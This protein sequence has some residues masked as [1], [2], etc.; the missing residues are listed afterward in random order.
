MTQPLAQ[1]KPEKHI[2]FHHADGVNAV[3]ALNFHWP[4][5]CTL[6]LLM[7]I[8]GIPAILIVSLLL[9]SLLFGPVESTLLLSLINPLYY[10]SPWA[11]IV[12][13]GSGAIFF[14][15]MPWQFSPALRGKYP[16]WHRASGRLVLLSGY[17]MAVSGIWMHLF[18]TPDE[19]GMRFIGLLALSCGMVLGFSMAFYAVLQR[20]F[21]RHRRWMCR[22]VAM[23]L[24]AV[25]PLFVQV[26][27]E[28]TVGQ[29]AALKPWLAPFFHDYGR[30]LGI[31]LNLLLVEWLLHRKAVQAS[32]E[33]TAGMH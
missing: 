25:T 27:A 32:G 10:A 17:S 19:L 5:V 14:L 24:A 13:G 6:W 26:I 2:N 28:L 29:V 22:A 11:V 20:Q 21:D 33:V 31:G 30:L 16:A 1:Q 7:A 9:T 3:G 4:V 23:T 12:H 15:T 8:P 18:L